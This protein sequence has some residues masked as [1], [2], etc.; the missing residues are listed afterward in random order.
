ML[1]ACCNLLIGNR[2]SKQCALGCTVLQLTP[3]SLTTNNQ[4]ASPAATSPAQTSAMTPEF[5]A[6][7]KSASKPKTPAERPASATA[8]NA[9]KYLAVSSGRSVLCFAV[10]V[11]H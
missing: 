7:P 6:M 2:I 9:T 11:K 3:V 5:E 10:S 8:A 4:Q 1:R